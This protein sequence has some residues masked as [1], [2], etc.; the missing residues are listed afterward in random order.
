[1]EGC[2]L[3]AARAVT[4]LQTTQP[5]EADSAG[6]PSGQECE[7]TS[8]PTDDGS[9]HHCRRSPPLDITP[10]DARA[11]AMPRRPLSRRVPFMQ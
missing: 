6:G 9:P 7:F 10:D 8:R 3:R 2:G 5:P 4:A 11:S 1:M